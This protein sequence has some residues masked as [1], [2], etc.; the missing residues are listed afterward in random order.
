M[1][2]FSASTK[3]ILAGKDN[4]QDAALWERARQETMRLLYL[5]PQ[6]NHLLEE[7]DCSDFVLY[8]TPSIDKYITVYD[9]GQAPYEVFIECIVRRRAPSL[10]MRR[11]SQSD[12]EESITAH[13][14]LIEADAVADE[15][16]VYKPGSDILPLMEMPRCFRRLCK[17]RR[18]SYPVQ[19]KELKLLSERLSVHWIRKGFILLVTTAPYY[20]LTSFPKSLSLFLGVQEEFLQSYLMTADTLL[21]EKR[22]RR[23]RLITS[24]NFHYRRMIQCQWEAGKNGSGD[25]SNAYRHNKQ[26]MLKKVG[27]L[28]K[29]SFTLSHSQVA[30]LVGVARGTVNSGTYAAKRIIRECMDDT[31]VKKYG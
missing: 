1:I 5:I 8:C 6:Q 14:F 27:E 25:V 18:S 16:P 3:I 26:Q 11:K 29:Q 24:M 15:Q 21:S 17:V 9:P 19:G 12:W 4:P 28:Q 31:P 23:D 13:P 22:A 10:L 2:S 30:D 20:C 7:E